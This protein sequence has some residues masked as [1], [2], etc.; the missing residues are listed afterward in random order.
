MEPGNRQHGPSLDPRLR[1]PSARSAGHCHQLSRMRLPCC[2]TRAGDRYL[3]E[4]VLEAWKTSSRQWAG[5]LRGQDVVGSS[6]SV[7]HDVTHV[8]RSKACHR[9][10]LNVC[11]VLILGMQGPHAA[12]LNTGR[13]PSWR[14]TKATELSVQSRGPF[15]L[16]LRTPEAPG[17]RADRLPS[18]PS[19]RGHLLFPRFML[20]QGHVQGGSSPRRSCDRQSVAAPSC[21]P[22]SGRTVPEGPALFSKLTLPPS[23]TQCCGGL[24]V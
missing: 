13:S 17:A 8:G 6:E 10:S 18:G 9:C 11:Q 4:Q 19:N 15:L 24:S 20:G 21:A 5:Q 3:P 14:K 2:R 16:S 22:C 1:L 7:H 12:G 23:Q